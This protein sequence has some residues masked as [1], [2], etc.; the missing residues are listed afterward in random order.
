[1]Y[2]NVYLANDSDGRHTHPRRHTISIPDG[3][4]PPLYYDT[5]SMQLDPKFSMDEHLLVDIPPTDDAMN[6]LLMTDQQL[7][8]TMFEDIQRSEGH[9]LQ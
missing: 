7:T 5:L 3:M 1:M 9:V 4:T 6:Q 8:F 2:D